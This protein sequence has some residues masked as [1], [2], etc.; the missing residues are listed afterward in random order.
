MAKVKVFYLGKHLEGKESRLLYLESGRYK[1]AIGNVSEKKGYK[2]I[3]GSECLEIPENIL[4]AGGNSTEIDSNEV[5]EVIKQARKGE[6]KA[7][8]SEVDRLFN[9]VLL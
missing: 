9:E 6:S 2:I 3:Q 8:D 1:L 5:A 4:N 7:L